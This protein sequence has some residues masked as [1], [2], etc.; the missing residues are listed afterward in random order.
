MGGG[1]VLASPQIENPIEGRRR[2]IYLTVVIAFEI[3]T[4]IVKV[5]SDAA[6]VTGKTA[7]EISPSGSVPID[8]AESAVLVVAIIGL[9]EWKKW[10][11]YLILARLAVTI[12][13]QLF[14]YHSLGQQLIGGYDGTLNVIFDF[15]GAAN[16]SL[17][18][19]RKWSYFD[20]ARSARVRS[21]AGTSSGTI[22]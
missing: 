18:V 22:P 17:A 8:L 1:Q 14:V 19:Y 7:L 3:L 15:V 21:S 4:V 16:I 13:V 2:G 10:G 20:G 12:L 9:L 11:F 5:F 6:L